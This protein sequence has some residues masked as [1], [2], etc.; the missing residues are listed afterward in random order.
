MRCGSL[1]SFGAYSYRD[2]IYQRCVISGISG[3]STKKEKW[4][5]CVEKTNIAFSF[6]V[7]A[8]YVRETFHG[9]SKVSVSFVVSS[10]THTHTRARMHTHIHLFSG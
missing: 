7:G 1:D 3:I 6:P 5:T 8:I 10:R 4:L 2:G 9:N